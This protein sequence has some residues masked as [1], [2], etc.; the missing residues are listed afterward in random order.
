MAFLLAGQTIQDPSSFVPED[1][2]IGETDTAADGSL[3]TDCIAVKTEWTLSWITLLSSE[4]AVLR[5]LYRARR[6]ITFS[7]PDDEG[8]QQEAQVIIIELDPGRG[9]I[10]PT[11][12]KGVDMVLREV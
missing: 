1:I 7:Y 3:K 12:Y 11:Y 8:E 9:R 10:M 5:T 4:Y 6:E 2:I